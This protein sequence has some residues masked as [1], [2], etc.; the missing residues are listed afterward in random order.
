MPPDRNN[1]VR[2][3][4]SLRS[5]G[6]PPIRPTSGQKRDSSRPPKGGN[7]NAPTQA[8]AETD[9][10]DN[11]EYDVEA[12]LDSCIYDGGKLHYKIRWKNYGPKEDSWSLAEDVDS[13]ALVEKFH[14]ENPE[15][16]GPE[17]TFKLEFC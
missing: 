9:E 7:S 16:I 17:G 2:K 1:R 3:P 13:P 4:V 5:L 14:R 6:P 11:K 8:Q 15:K 10:T 12:I